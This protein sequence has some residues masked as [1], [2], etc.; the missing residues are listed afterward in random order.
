MARWQARYQPGQERILA[1]ALGRERP[2]TGEIN[3]K[4]FTGEQRALPVPDLANLET[5][6]LGHGHQMAGVN[7]VDLP[8]RLST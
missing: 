1:P 7:G 8:A 2:R 4:P 3:H 5:D 6:A